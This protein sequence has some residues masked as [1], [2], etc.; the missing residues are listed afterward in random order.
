MV[1][2]RGAGYGVVQG[3]LESGGSAT[4]ATMQA[5]E[6]ARQAAQE[7]GVSQEAAD[8]ALAA[9][10]LAAAVASGED[11]LQ[12][13]REALPAELATVGDYVSDEDASAGS[14]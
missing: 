4:E 1:A 10:A 6:A 12:A 8:T 7:L 13:V 3:T 9:G 2:L 11:A 5:L 14:G